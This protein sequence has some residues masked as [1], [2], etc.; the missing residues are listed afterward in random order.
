MSFWTALNRARLHPIGALPHPVGGDRPQQRVKQRDHDRTLGSNQSG[1]QAVDGLQGT[2]EAE[3]TG[4]QPLAQS[5]PHHDRSDEMRGSHRH[6]QCL[7]HHLR[8]AAPQHV[9]PESRLDRAQIECTVPALA[10]EIRHVVRA[11][12]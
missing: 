12:A 9:H 2:C 11:G 5:C 7:P 3:L 1:G 4:A 8:G 10:R 6:P